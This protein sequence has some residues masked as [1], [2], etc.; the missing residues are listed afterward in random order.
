MSAEWF[1]ERLQGHIA[2]A[3]PAQLDVLIAALEA[4]LVARVVPQKA[5]LMRA[6][7]HGIRLTLAS[8]RRYAAAAEAEKEAA[9]G[10]D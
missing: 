9:H 5:A 6:A 7:V 3:T 1:R 10:T 2:D 8:S 4:A